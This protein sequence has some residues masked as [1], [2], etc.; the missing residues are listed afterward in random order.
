MISAIALSQGE[1]ALVDDED[2][3]RALAV[4][5]WYTDRKGGT[6]YAACHRVGYMHRFILDARPGQQVDH[7]NGDGLDNQRANLRLAT[8]AENQANARKRPVAT[9]QYKGVRR[10]A[11]PLKRPWQ[12]YLISH[13]VWHYLGYFATEEEAARAYDRA[14]STEWGDFARTNF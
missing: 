13:G 8:K 10:G 4:G 14:A 9:S 3:E 12:A 6:S 2:L 11:R 1:V 7:V 5:P